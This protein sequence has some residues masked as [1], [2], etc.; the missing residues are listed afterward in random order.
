MLDRRSKKTRL[1]IF[2]AF[3]ILLGRKDFDKITVGDI[4]AEADIGRSTFYHHFETKDLLFDAFCVD[5]FDHVFEPEQSLIRDATPMPS[6][7]FRDKLVHILMHLQ[8]QDIHL[9]NILRG[10]GRPLFMKY[11][12]DYLQNSFKDAIDFSKAHAPEEYVLSHTADGFGHTLYWWIMTHPEKSAEE[13]ADY[14]LALNLPG[15]F[16][17][18]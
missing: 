11:L 15:L 14:Y 10:G 2:R 18:K 1:A 4:I 3:R 9:Q 13:I 16:I 12:R 5:I 6:Q 8:S 7:T 17:K